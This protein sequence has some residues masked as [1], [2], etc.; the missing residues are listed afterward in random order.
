MSWWPHLYYYCF[1]LSRAAYNC[2]KEDFELASPCTLTK[3]KFKVKTNDGSSYI[4][5][6]FTN[7]TIIRQGACLLLLDKVC[8]KATLQYHG[9]IIF[10]KALNKLYFPVNAILGYMIV[11]LFWGLKFICRMLAV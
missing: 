5:H 4:K 3:L 1:A 11:T 7:S 10:W 9:E 8:V 6:I 2:V